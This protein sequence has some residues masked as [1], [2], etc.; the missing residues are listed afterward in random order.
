MDRFLLAGV[1][2]LLLNRQYRVCVQL[3]LISFPFFFFRVHLYLGIIAES[4]LLGSLIFIHA[5]YYGKK[6]SLNI[7]LRV[8]TLGYIVFR[9]EIKAIGKEVK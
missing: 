4:G 6:L 8:I 3:S 1:R 7:E 9:G 5:N 2:G